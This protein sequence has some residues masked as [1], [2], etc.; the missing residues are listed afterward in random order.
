MNNGEDPI[1]IFGTCPHILDGIDGI[2]HAGV[3][4]I[5]HT[6]EIKECGSQ[7]GELHQS[8]QYLAPC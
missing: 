7:R 1:R 8:P 3:I 5:Y 6:Q 2:V 4:F